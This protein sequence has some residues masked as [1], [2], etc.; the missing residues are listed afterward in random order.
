MRLAHIFEVAVGTQFE[1][2]RPLTPQAHFLTEALADADPAKQRTRDIAGGPE[3]FGPRLNHTDSDWRKQ[4]P[5]YIFVRTAF[6]FSM[7]N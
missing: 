2:W 6:P 7:L 1:D 4:A 3:L 5:T